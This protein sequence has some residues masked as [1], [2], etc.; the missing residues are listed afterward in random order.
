LLLEEEDETHPQSAPKNGSLVLQR[1]MLPKGSCL[2]LPL[3]ESIQKVSTKEEEEEEE[4]EESV[5]CLLDP[6]L[7]IDLNTRLG[8]V[9]TTLI[10]S[11]L[12][13]TGT[14]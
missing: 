10:F 3:V 7:I 4:E 6:R 1:L 11:W 14:F 13:M 5:F 12:L 9:N 2:P 8:R